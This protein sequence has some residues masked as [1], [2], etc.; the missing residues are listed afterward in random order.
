MTSRLW[1][2]REGYGSDLGHRQL[3]DPWRWSDLSVSP[4]QQRCGLHVV[5]RGGAIRRRLEDHVRDVRYFSDSE[6]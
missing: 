2:D 5:D 6:L 1:C 4:L 3:H